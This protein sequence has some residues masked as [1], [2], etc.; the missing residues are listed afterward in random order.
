MLQVSAL[1]FSVFPQR[2][3]LQNAVH[4]IWFRRSYILPV[5]Q[6]SSDQFHVNREQVFIMINVNGILVQS[7]TEA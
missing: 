1:W 3:V 4:A 2:S 6:V 5:L 7:N